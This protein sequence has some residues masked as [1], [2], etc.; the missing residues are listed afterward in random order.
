[1]QTEQCELHGT[2]NIETIVLIASTINES[3]ATMEMSGLRSVQFILP[4]SGGVA[5]ARKHVHELTGKDMHCVI[6]NRG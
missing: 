2:I 5:F 6:L 1:L 4:T 3:K